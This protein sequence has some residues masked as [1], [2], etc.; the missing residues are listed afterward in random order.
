MA[1]SEQ[2]F[3]D[4]SST[5]DQPKQATATELRPVGPGLYGHVATRGT[6]V[7]PERTTAQLSGIAHGSGDESEMRFSV[8]ERR[9]S[10]D[11]NPDN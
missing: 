4:H 5:F 9:S 7:V 10:H 1:L 8:P 2:A 11:F 3:G 6:V